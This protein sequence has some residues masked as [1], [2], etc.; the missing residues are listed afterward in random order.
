MVPDMPQNQPGAPANLPPV[1]SQ[2]LPGQGSAALPPASVGN[3]GGVPAPVPMNTHG[4]VPQGGI[5]SV[6]SGQVGSGDLSTLETTARVRQLVQ[7]YANDPFKLAASFDQL[8][9]GYL[10]Q[11]YHVVPNAVDK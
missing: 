5:P 8:K 9:N 1:M 3:G 10:A 11:H 2:P 7:Q 6:P 4:V